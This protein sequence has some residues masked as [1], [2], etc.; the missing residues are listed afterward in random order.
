VPAPAIAV[1]LTALLV[2]NALLIWAILGR[3]RTAGLAPGGT[4]AVAAEPV[5]LAMEL[6]RDPEGRP[7]SASGIRL[8][9]YDRIVRIVSYTFFAITLV[10]VAGGGLWPDSAPAI[11]LLLLAGGIVIFLLHDREPRLPDA[12]LFM[13]E[14]AA[15]VTF[16]TVLIMLTGGIASPYFFGY[17]LIVVVAALV[18]GGGASLVLA[19]AITAAF[20]GALLVTRGGQPYTSEQIV[21]VAIDVL[22]LWLL[23]YLASVV[24]VEQRKTRDTALRLSLHDPL[25]RL[26]NRTF[27]F[28]V[29]EREI[30]RAGRTN[31]RF[32]LLMLDLDGLKPVNDRYG[33]YF[34]DRMLQAVAEAV[35]QGIRV[36]DTAARYGGDEFVVLLPETDTDGAAVVAEKLRRSVAAIRLNAGTELLSSTASIG[37]VA[38]PDDGRTADALTNRADQVMYAAKRAGR[39]RVSIE[40]REAAEQP[41]VPVKSTT[42]APRR[43]RNAGTAIVPAGPARART[44]R[45]APAKPAARRAVAQMTRRIEH[46]AMS[47]EP[48]PSMFSD[49]YPTITPW[50]RARSAPW[51]WSPEASAAAATAVRG[52]G[53]AGGPSDGPTTAA[54][55]STGTRP[56]T[57]LRIPTTRIKRFLVE[58]PEDPTFDRTM[59]HFLGGDEAAGTRF[60]P[61][62]PDV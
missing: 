62:A 5:D 25:T 14:G 35:K 39:N 58:H 43:P 26:Y 40:G 6:A 13:V 32:S 57:T 28:A 48:R 23:S 45:T 59:D 4:N 52:T 55:S 8:A 54:G 34:G 42:S 18:T 7:A 47:Q 29:I 51:V 53:D 36:I 61:E 21:I 50:T 20:L 17:F 2:G 38:F 19:A 16:F 22:A 41:A 46:R 30:A 24:A 37:V 11:Y 27:L 3:R 49:H 12:D 60:G 10:V 33:H 44:A 31:R 1:V 9:T 56:L 15:A